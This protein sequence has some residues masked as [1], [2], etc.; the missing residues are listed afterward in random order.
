MFLRL[1]DWV[2]GAG[3]PLLDD[4]DVAAA[5]VHLS[6][7]GINAEWIQGESQVDV[8][9]LSFSVVAPWMS[10]QALLTARSPE[11]PLCANPP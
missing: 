1:L 3:E 11:N 9:M 4:V 6:Q 8:C 5:E 10:A 7:G 2:A